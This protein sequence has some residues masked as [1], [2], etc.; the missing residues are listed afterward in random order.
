MWGIRLLRLFLTL[1]LGAGALVG[2]PALVA[3]AGAAALQPCTV[4][5]TQA[6]RAVPAYTGS[7]SNGTTLTEF[8][9]D[10]VDD[11]VVTDIDLTIDITHPDAARLTISQLSPQTRNLIPNIFYLTSDDATGTM[12][13]AYTFDE[14]TGARTLSGT[15]PPPGTYAP[16]TAEK[17]LEGHPATGNWD[18]WVINA[19]SQAGQVRS[20]TLTLTYATCDTD[21]DGV[22]EKADNCPTA[23]NADQVN[24]DGDGVGDACDLDIDGDAL[25]NTDDGCPL[26][27]TTT[28]SG[29]PS[30]GRAASLRYTKAT[31]RLKVVVRS[32]A[33]ACKSQATVTLFRTRP[34]RDTKLVV[35][36]TNGKGRKT[37]KA[38]ARSGRYYVRVAASVAAGQAECGHARS[39]RT[40]V[41]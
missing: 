11:R 36:T 32:D 35:A 33:P 14:E 19:S 31:R 5:H 23:A 13:G 4:G 10:I 12:N 3:S 16:V 41:P 22:E 9:F 21:G 1:A 34:G 30:V 7:E 39:S 29:C 26:V 24:R 6:G 20:V 40:R 28:T 25:A 2:A 8:A 17:E 37:W 27:A 15:D 18:T 38:P